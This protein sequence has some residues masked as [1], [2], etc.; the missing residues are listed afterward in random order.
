MHNDDQIGGHTWHN[1]GNASNVEAAR[2]EN[3]YNLNIVHPYVLLKINI[4]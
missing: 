2:V 4:F 3:N 1:H